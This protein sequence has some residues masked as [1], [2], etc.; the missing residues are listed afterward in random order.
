[1]H[2]K[3]KLL[4]ALLTWVARQCIYPLIKTFYCKKEQFCIFHLVLH[5]IM[6]V[7]LA[8]EEMWLGD[9]LV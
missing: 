8:R 7:W 6:K 2:P 4:K 1:M 9:K 3:I 5:L